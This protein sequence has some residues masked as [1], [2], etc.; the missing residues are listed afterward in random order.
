M[1]RHGERLALV[2]AGSQP[3][4][5]DLAYITYEDVPQAILQMI[6]GGG[7][8]CV[9]QLAE[10]DTDKDD[11]EPCNGCG[12]CSE[13]LDGSADGHDRCFL[14]SVCIVLELLMQ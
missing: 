5:E 7:I 4:N 12:R 6:R 8:F 1:I 13:T 2:A 10:E 11:V 9:E 14:P 3:N